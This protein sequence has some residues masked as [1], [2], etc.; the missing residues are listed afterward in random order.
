MPKS[1]CALE[2][3]G[4][5]EAALALYQEAGDWASVIR[6]LLPVA[7]SVL[8]HGRW[9]T[10]NHWITSLPRQ[11]VEVT[12]WLAFWCGA[13]KGQTNPEAGR[14]I[15]EYAYAHFED[16]GDTIGQAMSAAAVI[17]SYCRLGRVHRRRSVDRCP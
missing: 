3:D 10:L 8:A 15:L 1:A 9:Q 14:T 2:E 4:D 17:D 6:L 13:C 5:H 16:A 11:A 12:P 7:P